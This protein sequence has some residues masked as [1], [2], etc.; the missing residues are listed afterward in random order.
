M[1]KNVTRQ[2][3]EYSKVA[4]FVQN[5]IKQISNFWS[6]MHIMESTGNKILR[7]ISNF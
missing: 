1:G 3:T 7:Q 5:S 4:T 6:Y 2:K